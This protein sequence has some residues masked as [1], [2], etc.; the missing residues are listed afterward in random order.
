MADVDSLLRARKAGWSLEQPFYRSQAFHDLDM[1]RVFRRSW[2]FAGHACEIKKPGDFFTFDVGGD[3]LI[4]IRQDDGSICA[5]FN[6]CRH[7]GSVICRAPSGHKRRFVCPYHQW[8]YDLDGSLL[9]N[10]W[11]PKDFDKSRFG[12]ARAAVRVVAGLIFV[13]L[14][15]APQPFEPARDLERLLGLQG[16][17][18][19]KVAFQETYDIGANWKLVIENQRE[20]Y[21]CPASHK[22]YARVQL[23]TD[24]HDPDKQDALAA[25]NSEA[26]QKWEALGIDVSMVRSDSNFNGLWWRTNRAPFRSPCISETMDGKQ[27]APLMGGYPDPDVGNA[28]ANTYPNFWL[29]ASCDHAHTMRV[30]PIDAT[31][32]RITASWIVNEHAVEGKDYRVEDLIAFSKLVNDEDRQIV[33]DQAIGIASSRYRPGPYT[34]SRG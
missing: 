4:V 3:S 21:H 33:V 22:T 26:R 32:T 27:I 20:C 17:E 23:D 25:R 15:E 28:R 7:R 13:N 2:L 8:T 18:S 14:A 10:T 6:V 24:V 16:I 19:G 9:S 12:L 34:K 5:L 1:E 29:H 31:T 11:M 30:I